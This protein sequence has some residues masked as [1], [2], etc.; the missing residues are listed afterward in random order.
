VTLSEFIKTEW[1]DVVRKARP[2]WTE[3]QFEAAWA[4]FVEMKRRRRMQ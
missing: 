1:C 3:E 4:A 2:D